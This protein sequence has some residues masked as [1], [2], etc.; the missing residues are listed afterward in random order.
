M[1][2]GTFHLFRSQLQKQIGIKIEGIAAVFECRSRRTVQLKSQ[3]SVGLEEK[4]TEKVISIINKA[5]VQSI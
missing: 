2:N 4:E 5:K 3:V 1:L